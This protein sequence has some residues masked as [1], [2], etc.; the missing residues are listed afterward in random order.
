[1]SLTEECKVGVRS[2]SFDLINIGSFFTSL[3]IA[4]DLKGFHDPDQVHSGKVEDTDRKNAK[5]ASDP[6]L[7][8]GETLEFLTS[9]K[10]CFL[11]AGVL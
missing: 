5:F 11:P 6:Y 7:P 1:M 4:F 9:H 10:V 3:N 8:Y 2:I